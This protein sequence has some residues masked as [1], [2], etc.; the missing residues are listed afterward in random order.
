VKTFLCNKEL[1]ITTKEQRLVIMEINNFI[2]GFIGLALF[3]LT[4]TVMFYIWAIKLDKQT[5]KE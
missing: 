3:I 2:I 4:F 1:Y 5:S